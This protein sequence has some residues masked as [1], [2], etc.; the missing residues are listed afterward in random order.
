[1]DKSMMLAMNLILK[2]TKKEELELLFG[3]NTKINVNFVNY[4]TN[5]KLYHIDCKLHIGILNEEEF[6]FLYPDSIHTIIYDVWNILGYHD[7]I[8][9]TLSYE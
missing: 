4:L 6:L 7:T 8:S 5:K 9:I 2:L 3:P 1:M